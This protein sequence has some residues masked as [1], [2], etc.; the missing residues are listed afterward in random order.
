[1]TPRRAPI[2]PEP[3]AFQVLRKHHDVSRMSEAKQPQGMGTINT[4]LGGFVDDL[5][6][7]MHSIFINFVHLFMPVLA[8]GQKDFCPA[9]Q[10]TVDGECG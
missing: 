8:R 2:G 4:D 1:M 10:K 9:F 6:W 5:L 3:R 7:L